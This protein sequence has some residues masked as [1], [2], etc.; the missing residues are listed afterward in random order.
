MRGAGG[1]AQIHYTLPEKICSFHASSTMFGR[2]RSA[3]EERI[4][5]K[6]GRKNR[7]DRKKKQCKVS[8]KRKLELV[9][10]KCK[11]EQTS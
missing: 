4:E 11:G 5:E 10:S 1:S 2:R 3:S 6:K 7:N 9:N 8:V